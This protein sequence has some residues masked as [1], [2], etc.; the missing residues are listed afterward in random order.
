MT[1]DRLATCLR[2]LGWSNHHL[3]HLLGVTE[4]R[5]R[6]WLGGNPIPPEVGPWLDALAAAHNANPPPTLNKGQPTC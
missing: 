6:R 3:A 1:P 5:V 2:L 4:N